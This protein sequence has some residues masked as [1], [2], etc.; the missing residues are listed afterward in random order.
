MGF[1]PENPA[2]FGK[3]ETLTAIALG[4][5][6]FELP[7]TTLNISTLGDFVIQKARYGFPN[8]VGKLKAQKTSG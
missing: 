2:A 1:Q 8:H 6:W 3:G 7:W 4:A 5:F